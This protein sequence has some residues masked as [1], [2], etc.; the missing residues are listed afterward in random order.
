MDQENLI[1]KDKPIWKQSPSIRRDAKKATEGIR[2][3]F[4]I[5]KYIFPFVMLFTLPQETKAQDSTL[6]QKT[7][8]VMEEVS[9]MASKIQNLHVALFSKISTF[10]NNLENTIFSKFYTFSTSLFKTLTGTKFSTHYQ[11]KNQFKK[12]QIQMAIL[13]KASKQHGEKVKATWRDI[14]TQ[15]GQTSVTIAKIISTVCEEAD[16]EQN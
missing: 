11:T 4:K 3:K 9:K 16:Q 15:K 1:K 12:L 6:E 2:K 14:C 8:F 13:V 10:I 5:L 7:I